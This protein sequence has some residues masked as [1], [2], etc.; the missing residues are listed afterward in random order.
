MELQKLGGPHCL[1]KA[2]SRAWSTEFR[3]ATNFMRLTAQAVQ[4][5]RE[6]Q[7]HGRDDREAVAM[8]IEDRVIR[9]NNLCFE[10]LTDIEAGDMTI[11]SKGVEELYQLHGSGMR[12]VAKPAEAPRFRS[13]GSAPAFNRPQHTKKS[14]RD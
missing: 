14:F 7:I 12:A 4:Q 5:M 3:E 6:C 8:L 13:N 9:A 10:L 11:E 2:R 1:P